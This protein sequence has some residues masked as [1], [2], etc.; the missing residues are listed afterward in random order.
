LESLLENESLD[1]KGGVL[2]ISY[3]LRTDIQG[4]K[5]YS[6]IISFNKIDKIIIDESSLFNVKAVT[7]LLCPFFIEA[8]TL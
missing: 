4:Y 7:H 8:R 5:R 6:A 3:R 1:Y 2:E